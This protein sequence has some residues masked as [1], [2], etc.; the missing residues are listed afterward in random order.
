MLTLVCCCCWAWFKTDRFG[1]R[2]LAWSSTRNQ[3]RNQKKREEK[4]VEKSQGESDPNAK[5]EF[6]NGPCAL[7]KKLAK[8]VSLFPNFYNLAVI[9]NSI[10]KLS[11]P[12]VAVN[13]KRLKTGIERLFGWLLSKRGQ[14]SSEEESR[15]QQRQSEEDTIARERAL[16]EQESRKPVTSEPVMFEPIP[17]TVPS[18]VVPELLTP[19]DRICHS[20]ICSTSCTWTRDTANSL[21]QLPNMTGCLLTHFMELIQNYVNLSSLEK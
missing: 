14:T 15:R 20:C 9:P 11:K 19:A 3:A 13:M 16:K 5:T 17:A 6:K 2:S 10:V 7:V 18:P 12:S 1:G 4:L 8:T 21:G